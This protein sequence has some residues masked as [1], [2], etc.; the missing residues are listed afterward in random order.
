MSNAFQ[1]ALTQHRIQP[2]RRTGVETLQVN[3]GKRCNQAC[4]HC[5]VDA[6]PTRTEAASDSVIAR[7]IWLLE[8]SAS[9]HTVDITGGAPELH[10]G[11]RRLVQSARALNLHVMDRCNL[12]IL[13]EPGQEDTASFLAEHE[14]EVV[15]SLPCYG[16]ENV[17]RQRGS[18]VFDASIAGL[19]QLNALGYGRADSPLKLNL[20]YNPLGA[21]L[22]PDQAGLEADYKARLFDDYGVRFNALYTITNMPIARFR[23]DLE[24]QGH[25]KNYLDRLE[26]AFNPAAV[27]GVMCRSMLSVGHDGRLFDCDFNQMLDMDIGP[28]IWTIE[29][30]VEDVPTGIQTDAHCLGC[31]AGAGSSCGGALQ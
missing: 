30:L 23:A 7:I 24:R 10:P 13:S 11:F 25:L 4:R 9:I 2:L 18:G 12:T 19:Q 29:S 21:T 31:T 16:P 14:V 22:P 17:D 26:H 28:N 27:A 6:S 1:R 20:V 5:H 8:R 15:A 3:L